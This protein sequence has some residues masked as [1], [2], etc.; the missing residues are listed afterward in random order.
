[1]NLSNPKY[2]YH[3]TNELSFLEFILPKMSI[4]TSPMKNMNDPKE[5]KKANIMA[6]S[7]F[8]NR[9]ESIGFLHDKFNH[10]LQNN[11]QL[12]CFAT[13]K[14]KERPILGN[15]EDDME[16]D[17]DREDILK[18]GFTKFRMWSQYANNH[19]GVC[20]CFSYDDMK[21][22]VTDDIVY[23]GYVN[24]SDDISELFNACHFELPESADINKDFIINHIKDKK[25]QLFFN[26]FSDWKDEREYRFVC[27]SK[28]DY[29]ED[30]RYFDIKNSLKAIYLGV[31]F[32]ISLI[33]LIKH[34]LKEH[35]LETVEIV[36][37][38]LF[39]ATPLMT[40]V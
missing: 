39:N 29:V 7:D 6:I 30:Y 36:R 17:L 38:A 40:R 28:S 15:N 1:M 16:L 5:S 27:F 12:I 22:I 25:K 34:Y 26:K 24:Y 35:D 33:P 10:Y 31:H 13:D 8:E 4:R 18:Y 21:K 19:R 32:P 3:Y 20:L 9:L 37:L 11:S 2:L 14:S 23:K